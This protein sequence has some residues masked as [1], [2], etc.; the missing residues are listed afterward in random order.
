MFWLFRVALSSVNHVQT[1]RRRRPLSEHCVRINLSTYRGNRDD[2]TAIVP[3]G[4]RC[5]V[6]ASERNL[7]IDNLSLL[8]LRAFT[9]KIRTPPQVAIHNV[10]KHKAYRKFK[11]VQWTGNSHDERKTQIRIQLSDRFIPFH[12]VAGKDVGCTGDGWLGARWNGAREHE[13]GIL[14]KYVVP[15]VG[16]ACIRRTR[17]RK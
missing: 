5:C 12:S 13:I 1:S 11:E 4:S 14:E 10:A 6:F 9:G 7:A 17:C 16:T 3:S 2:R 8:T 15:S